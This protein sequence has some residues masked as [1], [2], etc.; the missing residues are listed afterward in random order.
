MVLGGVG[1]LAAACGV[2][3]LDA[4]STGKDAGASDA[5]IAEGAL[6][7]YP[8]SNVIGF[9][10]TAAAPSFAAGV[11]KGK[12]DSYVPVTGPNIEIDVDG[13]SSFD[14]GVCGKVIFGSGDPLPLPTSA[15]APPPD[16]PAIPFAGSV[17]PTGGFPYEF[18]DPGI[19]NADAGAFH[20]NADG[21]RF[22]IPVN[23]LQVYKAWCN[24][25]KSYLEV[26]GEN[27]DQAQTDPTQQLIGAASPKYGCIPPHAFSNAT[28]SDGNDCEGLN[29]LSIHGISCAQAEYCITGLCSCGALGLASLG[30]PNQGCTADTY[31]ARFDVTVSDDG[32]TM[33]GSFVLP[34]RVE[35][36][37]LT[38]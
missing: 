5:G 36:V 15:D 30:N 12:F 22:T 17:G 27:I 2:T 3:R 19:F 20:S 28:T 11:W 16:A 23:L 29:G 7:P 21:R 6:W 33:T 8:P 25:Q 38:R 32:S 1:A 18:H 10:C 34:T 9:E 31:P 24:M 13:T 4:G 35:T 26:P 37:H 14:H